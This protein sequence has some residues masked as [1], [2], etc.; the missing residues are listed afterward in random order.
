MFSLLT[1]LSRKWVILKIHEK[2]IP[3]RKSIRANNPSLKIR[4]RKSS[5]LPTTM[6]NPKTIKFIS[7]LY[8][9]IIIS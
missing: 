4:N 9:N 8:I 2:R 7:R 1:Q 6:N 5:F 3:I